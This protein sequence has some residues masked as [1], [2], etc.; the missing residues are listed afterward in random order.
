[1]DSQDDRLNELVETGEA[2]G[3]LASTPE[4]FREAVDAFRARDVERFQSTLSAAG[5][6]GH[7]HLICRLL[8]SKHC[9][10]ICLELCGPP[11]VDRELEVD[12]L[13]EFAK[14]TERLAQDEN[15]L[16]RF[17]DAVETR[18]VKAW[19]ALIQRQKLQRFCH[20]L[21]HWLCGVQCRVACSILC[22]PPPVITK[23]AEIPTSQISPQ[24]LAAGPSV[25]PGLTPPDNKPAGDGDHPF[26][27]QAHIEGNFLDVAGVTAYRV[28]W[29]ANPGGPWTPILAPLD[30]VHISPGG[31][32]SYQRN[33]DAGGWYAVADIGLLGPTQLTDWQTPAPDGLYYLRLTARNGAGVEFASPL[34]AALVDNTAPSGPAPGGRPAI[35][36]TQQGRTLDC[37]E[38]V[39][40]GG[41]PLTITVEAVDA[42]FSVLAVN[43][44]GGCGAA[45]PIFDKTYNGDLADQGAPAPGLP[46]V[47]NP[48]AAHV[49]P[50]C[51]VI[52]VEIWD[53]AIVNNSY[54]SRHYNAN[55]H[56]IT[57]A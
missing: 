26:G 43:L 50:C 52:F 20:Q 44:R 41:G 24:G 53:R 11:E 5:V 10:F 57:I 17:L 12:E 34:V 16:G 22:P 49:S 31:L 1:M 51:Y 38:T 19:R 46:I 30:D 48:W 9:I 33:P 37:C 42:N 36:I 28:D 27:G 56:S 23:V 6:F 4:A 15:L 54:G 13:L 45:V 32:M 29:A 2:I 3:K 21:C 39:K 35:S 47:W 7:C 25:P 55:W 40:R 14:V 8:C 18:E